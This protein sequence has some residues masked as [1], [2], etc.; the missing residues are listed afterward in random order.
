M[1]WDRSPHVCDRQTMPRTRCKDSFASVRLRWRRQ[2]SIECLLQAVR[3]MMYKK[4]SLIQKVCDGQASLNL[5]LRC[6]DC[7]NLLTDLTTI[8]GDCFGDRFFWWLIFGN[9]LLPKVYLILI[10]NFF[11]DKSWINH[12]LAIIVSSDWLLLA[13]LLQS[14]LILFFFISFLIHN[15][16]RFP[17]KCDLL[18]NSHNIMHVLVRVLFHDWS[19]L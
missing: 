10:Q 11:P 2:R 14:F 3:Q 1:D 6:L 8:V 7:M 4:S 13:P 19:D 5:T 18:C 9:C 12:L 16:F 15:V 17:G